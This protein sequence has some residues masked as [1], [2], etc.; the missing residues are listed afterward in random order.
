MISTEKPMKIM[1]L[2]DNNFV[3]NRGSSTV[4]I[5]NSSPTYSNLLVTQYCLNYIKDTIVHVLNFNLFA[6]YIAEFPL[7]FISGYKLLSHF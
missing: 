7:D 6:K 4:F 5:Q 2:I 3:S 1:G